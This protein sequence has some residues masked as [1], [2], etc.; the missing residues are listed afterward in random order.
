MAALQSKSYQELQPPAEKNFFLDEFHETSL[1]FVLHAA[2][3]ATAADMQELAEICRAMLTNE[4]R[5]LPLIG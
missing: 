3:L 1:L 4:T 2:D 5:V